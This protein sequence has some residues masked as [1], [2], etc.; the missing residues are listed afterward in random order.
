MDEPMATDLSAD[1]NKERCVTGKYETSLEGAKG[2]VG[3]GV[4]AGWVEL[5]L[6]VRLDLEFP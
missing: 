4:G 2:V 1:G 6:E 5:G 3:E